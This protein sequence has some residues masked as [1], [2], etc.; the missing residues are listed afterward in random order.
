MVSSDCGLSWYSVYS[1]NSYE[2]AFTSVGQFEFIGWLPDTTDA[3]SWK[4]QEID[5]TPYAG[6]QRLMV[7][8]HYIHEG[9]ND[10]Y[11]RNIYLGPHVAIPEKNLSRI[12]CFPNPTAGQVTVTTA[13]GNGILELTV[14]DITGKNILGLNKEQ[15][16]P[17]R[18]NID[19]SDQ[20]P[21]VYFVTVESERG[22]DTR[23]V[24]LVR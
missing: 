5:L 6:S 20:L 24:V 19:L 23:K 10:I 2:I 4:P 9:A 12:S 13:P 15:E 3:I 1:K 11:I 22:V 17:S 21:G 8:F 18:V 7:R 14:A 16:R